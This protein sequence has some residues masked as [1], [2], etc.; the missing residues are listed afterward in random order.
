VDLKGTFCEE[1]EWI[2]WFEN[3]NETSGGVVG[4]W[5]DEWR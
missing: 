3:A 1:V 2:L 4:G 5:V